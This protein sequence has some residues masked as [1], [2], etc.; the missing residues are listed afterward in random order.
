M[1]VI[2]LTDNDVYTVP[3]QAQT[4]VVLLFVLA[5]NYGLLPPL[6]ADPAR[7]RARRARPSSYASWGSSSRPSPSSSS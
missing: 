4:A 2:L 5:L 1:A 6:R 3:Q 7:H